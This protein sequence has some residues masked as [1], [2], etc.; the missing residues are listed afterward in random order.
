M[1][2]PLILGSAAVISLGLLCLTH[3]ATYAVGYGLA[4]RYC[5]VNFLAQ[6]FVGGA[7]VTMTVLEIAKAHPEAVPESKQA[8]FKRT[9]NWQI[10]HIEGW[11][12]E[13]QENYGQTEQAARSRAVLERAKRLQQELGDA[14]T[15]RAASLP[16][17]GD[18]DTP[19]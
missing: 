11:V 6:D 10:G 4:S 19:S 7:E 2:K 16:K 9:L 17:T 18:T 12:I 13:D 8:H 3:W 5:T 15:P 14:D 1:K